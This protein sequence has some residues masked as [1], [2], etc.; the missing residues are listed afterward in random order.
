M[1][2]TLGLFDWV[3]EIIQVK[4]DYKKFTNE[5]WGSFDPYMIHL[6]LSMNPNYLE[7]IDNIQELNKISKEKLYR[8]Y[9]GLIPRNN[10]TYFPYIKSKTKKLNDKKLQFISDLYECSI[11]EANEYVNLMDDEWLD[12]ILDKF[13]L[14]KKDKKQ[15][16]KK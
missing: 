16:N 11:D 12:N 10:R 7:L 2:K 6:V 15:L 14:D 9:S 1:K 8:I 4:S 3:K 5:D 13:G